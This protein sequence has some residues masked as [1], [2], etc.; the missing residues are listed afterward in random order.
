MLGGMDS[1]LGAALGGIIVGQLLSFGQYFIGSTI[2][3]IVFVLIGIL[4]YFR[5]NGLLGRGINIGI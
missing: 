2:Q 5:P 4:L 3:I 1:L